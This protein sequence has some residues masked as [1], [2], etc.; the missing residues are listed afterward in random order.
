LLLKTTGGPYGSGYQVTRA[1]RVIPA[2]E[3]IMADKKYTQEH[4][5]DMSLQVGALKDFAELL[6]Y[7][8]DRKADGPTLASIALIIKALLDPVEDFLSWAYTCA[9]IPEEEPEQAV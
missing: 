2:K 9:E 3:K 1:G 4:F 7:N 6:D 5:N 8:Y